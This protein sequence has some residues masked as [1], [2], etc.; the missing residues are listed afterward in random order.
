M[1]Y[2]RVRNNLITSINTIST[3]LETPANQDFD[4]I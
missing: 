1:G 2:Q 3:E 4:S